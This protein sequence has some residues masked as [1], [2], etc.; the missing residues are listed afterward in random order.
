MRLLSLLAALLAA[1]VLGGCASKG[2]AVVDSIQAV[3]TTGGVSK[4]AIPDRPDPRFRYLRVEVEGFVP[5]LMVLGYVDADPLG[6][7]EV[8]YSATRETLRLQNG[9]VLGA[10]GTLHDWQAVTW[11]PAPPAWGD[12]TAQGSA[13]V[14]QRD[15][16]VG[17]HFGIREQMRLSA[18]QGL[19]L[20]TLAQTLPSAKA[21]SYQWYRESAAAG[22]GDAALPDA[23]FAWGKHLGEHTVVYSHQCLAPD[24]C[25][26]LQRWPLLEEAL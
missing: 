22:A 11:A 6:P 16:M 2:A 18:W 9:R 8:W 5:G 10:T 20:I 25:L 3:F 14:R 12:V 7:I 24:F 21:T 13:F 26:K 23:W 1:L 19:P 4:T 15:A 17:S